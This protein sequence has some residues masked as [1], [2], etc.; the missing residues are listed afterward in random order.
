[1]YISLVFQESVL[2]GKLVLR[3]GIKILHM[4]FTQATSRVVV[5]KIK[6]YFTQISMTANTKSAQH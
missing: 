6:F 1:M 4:G 3:A 5:E 2:C